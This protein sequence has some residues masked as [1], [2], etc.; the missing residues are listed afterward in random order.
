MYY[1]HQSG[2]HDMNGVW[3]PSGY[4]SPNGMYY[5]DPSYFGYTPRPGMPGY[6]YNYPPPQYGGNGGSGGGGGFIIL[7]I[8]VIICWCMCCRG[9]NANSGTQQ[10]SEPLLSSD[11]RNDDQRNDG[12]N[13]PVNPDD[14]KGWLTAVRA[15]YVN[16]EEGAVGRWMDA[17]GLNQNDQQTLDPY[18]D[19]V[20]QA[21]G[22]ADSEIRR[23]SADW[24]V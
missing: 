20:R 23:I 24:G 15:E 14:A 1:Y 13:C 16:R 8:I 2:W 7:L 6:G 22:D 18:E 12:Q 11:Q 4:Y 21:G 19:R 3:H 9:N 5:N 10:A 17:A